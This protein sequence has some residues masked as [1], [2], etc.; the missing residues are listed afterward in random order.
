[1]PATQTNSPPANTRGTRSLFS[2]ATPASESAPESEMD[3]LLGVKEDEVRQRVAPV[4]EA[5]A[6]PSARKLEDPKPESAPTRKAPAPV[7]MERKRSNE[8]PAL[9]AP[10]EL[11]LAADLER[12]A[13]AAADAGSA[14]RK[15]QSAERSDTPVAGYAA[16]ALREESLAERSVVHYLSASRAFR[17]SLPAP[18]QLSPGAP[19]QINAAIASHGFRLTA[20]LPQGLAPGEI[21]VRVSDAASRRELRERVRVASGQTQ[22]EFEIPAN[23]MGQGTYRVEIHDSRTSGDDT[24][25]AVYGLWLVDRAP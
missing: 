12:G 20:P 10:E 3:T 15:S 23:W 8:P 18:V 5:P 22:V 24:P 16:P 1:M 11:H 4:R 19:A 7:V 25:L 17:G 9:E 6:M 14:Y 13:T 2:Q 21:E